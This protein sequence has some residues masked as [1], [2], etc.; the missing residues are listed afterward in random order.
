VPAGRP[1]SYKPDYADQAY[2]LGLLGLTDE[3]LAAF[4]GVSHTTIYEW[5]KAHPEFAESRARGKLPADAHVATRLY[6]RALGY[7][8][9]AVKIFMPAGA[10]EPVVA[11]Y[12]EHYPPDTQAASW[13]L[14][15]RQPK[16]WRDR[17]EHTGADGGPMESEVVYRWETPKTD[18]K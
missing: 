11:D 1:S 17:Q 13:W 18:P 3:E 10:R 7:S 16:R 4:F 9:P 12:I 15:N 2:R 14:K 6:Q 8:H 5:D